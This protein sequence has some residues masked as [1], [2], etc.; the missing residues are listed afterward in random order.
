MHIK[1]I[2]PVQFELTWTWLKASHRKVATT[3]G[4]A[5]SAFAINPRN[6]A[7]RV[8]DE[9]GTGIEASFFSETNN[10]CKDN[11]NSEV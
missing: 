5:L 11:V 7:V 4:E 9:E 1:Q 3:F 2:I 6:G 8:Q 10:S